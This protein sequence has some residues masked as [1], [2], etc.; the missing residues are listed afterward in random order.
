MDKSPGP[1]IFLLFTT[2]CVYGL[3][4]AIRVYGVYG[5]LPHIQPG[6]VRWEIP[7]LISP[8]KVHSWAFTV[9]QTNKDENDFICKPGHLGVATASK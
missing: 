4:A 8:E 2:V 9:F 5:I 6:T 7:S 3:G 1:V